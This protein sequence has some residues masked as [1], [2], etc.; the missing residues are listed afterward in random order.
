[1]CPPRNAG[2]SAGVDALP[3]SDAAQSL[4]VSSA[5]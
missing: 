3:A 4:I 2:V 1:M 5:F